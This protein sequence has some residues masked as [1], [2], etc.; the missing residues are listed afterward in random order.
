MEEKELI[1]INE[2]LSSTSWRVAQDKSDGSEIYDWYRTRLR[3]ECET[4]GIKFL[5][6]NGIFGGRSDWCFVDKVHL[7]DNGYELCAEFLLES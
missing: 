2:N 3:R 4:R 5:D 6:A 1:R 7:T